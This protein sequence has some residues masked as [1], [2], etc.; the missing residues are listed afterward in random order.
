MENR[1]RPTIDPNTGAIIMEHVYEYNDEPG[2]RVCLVNTNSNH[3]EKENF[4][5]IYTCFAHP[6]RAQIYIDN[7]CTE[8][9]V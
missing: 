3:E 6:S 5:Y 8:V 1:I 4:K 2:E 9:L 7:D